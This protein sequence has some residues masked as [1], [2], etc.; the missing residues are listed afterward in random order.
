MDEI[1]KEIPDYTFRSKINSVKLLLSKG[2]LVVFTDNT[3][4]HNFELGVPHIIDSVKESYSGNYEITATNTQNDNRFVNNVS[5]S[6]FQIIGAQRSIVESTIKSLDKEQKKLE[7]L[8][9]KMDTLGLTNP[10]D[11]I[12]IRKELIGAILNKVDD[13]D[14]DRTEKVQIIAELMDS[15]LSI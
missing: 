1:L 14:I 4:G 13:P 12:D 8:I 15:M 7:F 6:S 9:S 3:S 11:H 5:R 2:C 10:K